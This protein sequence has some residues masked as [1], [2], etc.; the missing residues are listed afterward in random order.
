M[1]GKNNVTLSG[2][3]YRHQGNGIKIFSKALSVPRNVTERPNDS[4]LIT[5]HPHANII[6]MV[7]NGG[8]G[9]IMWWG[10]FLCSKNGETGRKWKKEPDREDPRWCF[11]NE[12]KQRQQR[13]ERLQNFMWCEKIQSCKEWDQ[14]LTLTF[15][16]KTCW[17]CREWSLK[18]LCREEQEDLVVKGLCC[19]LLCPL[20]VQSGSAAVATLVQQLTHKHVCAESR[21]VTE[22]LPHGKREAE[23]ESDAERERERGE[24]ISFSIWVGVTHRCHRISVFITMT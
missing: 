2:P 15:V 4:T 24:F 17:A 20:M 5:D 14:F 9:S 11:D 23:V 16:R 6:T 8:G 13:V 7:K 21:W 10:G 22:Q 3:P 19:G 1:S 18:S 12:S